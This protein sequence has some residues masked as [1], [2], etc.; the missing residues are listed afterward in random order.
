MIS[1]VSAVHSRDRNEIGVGL[2]SAGQDRLGGQSV[3][4]GPGH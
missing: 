4:L 3:M 1:R 2:G